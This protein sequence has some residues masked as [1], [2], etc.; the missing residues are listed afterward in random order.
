MDS[1]A[2]AL[3]PPTV[4]VGFLSFGMVAL[5]YLVT[6]EL[7]VERMNVPTASCQ[8]NVFRWLSRTFSFGG[9]DVIVPATDRAFA[10]LL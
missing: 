1:S 3:F 2:V 7:L 8:R 10:G 5:L 9:A 6:E 4:I